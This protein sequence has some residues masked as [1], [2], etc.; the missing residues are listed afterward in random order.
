MNKPIDKIRGTV[1]LC[2]QVYLT[3][4]NKFII[5]GTYNYI[6]TTNDKIDFPS[7]I[8][9]YVRFQVEQARSYQVEVVLA[10][11]NAPTIDEGIL[12]RISAEFTTR[13]PLEPGE[14]GLQFPSFQLV[15]PIPQDQIP[16]SGIV[17]PLIVCLRV[18]SHE[19]SSCRLYI[20]FLPP[21]DTHEDQSREEKE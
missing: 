5:A 7:G 19:V 14:K 8:S 3:Q 13:N 11:A 6:K 1:I 4:E 9:T 10:I 21:G 17:V 12:D 15:C 18:D 20:H 2:D 16:P